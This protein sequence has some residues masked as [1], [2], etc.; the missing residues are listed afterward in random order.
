L[1]EAAGSDE[2]GRSPAAYAGQLKAGL[3]FY[4]KTG[5]FMVEETLDQLFTEVL[6][7]FSNERIVC[8]AQQRSI[9]TCAQ[10]C[11]GG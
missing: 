8:A 5:N 9:G 1:P 10:R 3:R 2:P 6:M 4:A 11:A 7:A